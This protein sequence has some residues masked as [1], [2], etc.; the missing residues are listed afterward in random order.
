MLASSLALALVF[1]ESYTRYTIGKY[2][3]D[4]VKLFNDK[5]NHMTCQYI[6]DMMEDLFDILPIFRDS[7]VAKLKP[8]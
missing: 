2:N 8:E 7:F 6:I 1:M 3:Y 4:N 5:S